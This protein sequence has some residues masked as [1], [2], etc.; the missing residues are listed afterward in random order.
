[1]NKIIWKNKDSSLIDGLL[2]S[3]LPPITKPRMKVKETHIDGVDGSIVEELGYEAYDKSIKIGLRGKYDI[4][5]VIEY[6]SG[7]SQV[8]FSNEDD[9]YYNAT[10]VDKIDFERLVRFRT[11][12]VKFLVQPYKYP[13]NMGA[14]SV[15]TATNLSYVINNIGNVKSCP[16][17]T[18]KG[19]GLVEIFLDDVSMFTYLFPQGETEVVIDSEKQDAYLGS[20]LKNRNMNGDFIEFNV[21]LNTVRWS[22]A[23]T[24]IIFENWSRYL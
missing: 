18:L 17:I 7:S 16:K 14:L 13:L 23:L 19:S 4:D 6:F 11:A 12:K 9:K 3:E 10:I 15:D 24:E 21:G 2:I 5:E 20:I 1:M 8:T 22:G